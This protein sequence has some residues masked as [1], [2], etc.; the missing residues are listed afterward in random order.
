MVP[1]LL[2]TAQ[3][4][5]VEDEDMIEVYVLCWY[6][7]ML[8]GG[9]LV[10]VVYPLQTCFVWFVAPPCKVSLSVWICLSSAQRTF[11]I[12]MRNVGAVF[13]VQCSLFTKAFVPSYP[14]PTTRK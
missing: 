12:Q 11:A 1:V 7:G 10:A 8:V 3:S 2:N 5:A 4:K 13:N 6:A 9:L 14:V